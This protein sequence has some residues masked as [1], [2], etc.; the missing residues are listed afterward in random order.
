MLIRSSA[1]GTVPGFRLVQ[2]HPPPPPQL[3]LP[4][5]DDSL[6]SPFQQ[7]P[8]QGTAHSQTCLR[9]PSGETRNGGY[10]ARETS[11]SEMPRSSRNWKCC[12][13]V[14]VCFSVCVSEYMCVCVLYVRDRT[15][16]IGVCVSNKTIC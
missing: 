9:M 3:L 13:R 14:C 5:P 2:S 12:L 10:V 7:A 4:L 6:P 1:E 16:L 11:E 8:Q 15:Y